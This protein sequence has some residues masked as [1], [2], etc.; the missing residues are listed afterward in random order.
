MIYNTPI[1]CRIVE[2]EIQNG[3]NGTDYYVVKVLDGSGY[4][5]YNTTKEIYDV[6]EPSMSYT[7]TIEHKIY[8]NKDNNT[9]SQ[10]LKL[11]D[12]A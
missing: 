4:V 9:V 8:F 6:I 12:V 11:I 2:K 5:R 7:L 10:R 3:S 1:K